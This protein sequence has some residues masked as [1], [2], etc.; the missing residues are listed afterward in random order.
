VGGKK[1]EESRSEKMLEGIELADRPQPRFTNK[2]FFR[3]RLAAFFVG[4][5]VC[6]LGGYMS[7]SAYLAFGLAAACIITAVVV[8][9]L[10]RKGKLRSADSSDDS[11][12]E[13]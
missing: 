11:P 5:I 12:R 1:D 8:E 6:V 7:G 4:I 10:F 3:A 13:E 9:L 2:N